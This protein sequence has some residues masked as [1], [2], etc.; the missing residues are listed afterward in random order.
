M[1]RLMMIAATAA[2][3]MTASGAWARDLR[4]M[5]F[6]VRFANPSDGANVWSARRAVFMRTVRAANPDVIGTQ[7]LLRSQG[8]DIVAALPAYRW[9]GRDRDGGHDGEHMGVFYRTDRLKLV[10]SGDF[11]LSDTPE[12]PGRPA[13]GANLPRMVT[14]AVFETVGEKTPHRFLMADTHFA[15]RG[16]EDEEARTR[17][18]ALIAERLPAIARG[19]PIVLT[20]DLNTTVDSAAV[21]HLTAFLTDA[22][23]LARTKGAPT[24]TF[25]DFT[26]VPEPGKWID[27]V[28]VKGFRPISARVLT[29]HAGARYPSDHFPIVAVLRPE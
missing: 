24:G 4:V 20:G 19:L 17:S 29:T 26:G 23:A 6:N 7:E 5:T 21:K 15:H 22:S 10:Q 9:F 12:V 1:K 2:A 14:W 3:V 27:H 11:W 8:D 16:A 25:H 18:A 13:W 28:L